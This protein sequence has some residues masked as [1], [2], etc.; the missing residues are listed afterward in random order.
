M[1]RTHTYVREVAAVVQGGQAW[2]WH[3]VTLRQW[4]V[5]GKVPFGIAAQE[6]ELRGT[7]TGEIVKVARDRA[8]GLRDNRPGLN[9]VLTPVTD[10]SVTVV[11]VTHEDRLA[12]FGVGWAQ[13]VVRG[14]RRRGGGA[15]PHQARRSGRT[16]GGLCIPG[17]DLCRPAVRHAVGGSL[18][19]I[20][21]ETRRFPGDH[22]V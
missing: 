8:S 6:K 9:R 1:L 7:A 22:V 20:A 19:A 14:V 17:H 10:G 16:A 4:T 3:P 5:D 18:R 2:G 12:R 15:A 13:A 21:A 11:G